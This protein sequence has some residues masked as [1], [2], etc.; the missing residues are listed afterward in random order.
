MNKTTQEQYETARAAIKTG[1]A[2][3]LSERTMNKLWAKFF[4]IEDLARAAGCL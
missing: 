1:E 2:K 4:A 3:G